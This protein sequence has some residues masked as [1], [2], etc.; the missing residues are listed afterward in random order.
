MFKQRSSTG[1]VCAL[2]LIFESSPLTAQDRQE[3]RFSNDWTSEFVPSSHAELRNA[4]SEYALFARH[5]P[6]FAVSLEQN[7]SGSHCKIGCDVFLGTGCMKI[8][9]SA[10]DILLVTDKPNLIACKMTPIKET[11][12]DFSVH[13]GEFICLQDHDNDSIFDSIFMINIRPTDYDY[14]RTRGKVPRNK[15]EL[16]GVRYTSLNVDKF[17]PHESFARIRL[18]DRGSDK[19]GVEYE[20]RYQGRTIVSFG[21][22]GGF[23]VARQDLV[24]KGSL[25]FFEKFQEF[26]ANGKLWLF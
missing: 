8:S 3:D 1:A 18:P 14:G 23:N 26:S 7:L 20:L 4:N 17:E 2:F 5:R 6:K 21:Q 13:R 22:A 10:D 12:I 19:V 15:T 25:S 9:I 16:I 24:S 11:F